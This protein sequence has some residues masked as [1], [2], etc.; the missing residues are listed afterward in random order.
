MVLDAARAGD[1]LA[2]AAVS[3][4]A[5]YLSIAIANL[6]CIV[7]PERIVLSGDLATYADMFTGPV[8]ERIQGLVP[9]MPE[10][11]ASE[12]GM[13]AAVWAPS[14]SPCARRATRCIYNRPVRKSKC[15]RR[16]RMQNI[17]AGHTNSYHTYTLDEALDGIATAGFKYVELSAVRGWTEHV[18]LEATPADIAA[19]KAKLA[20]WGLT[21]ASLSGHSD[22]TTAT[23]LVDGKKAVDLCPQ[24]GI[25]LMNTA[26]GG[27]YSE[28]ENKA[29]FMGN[30]HELAD[31]AA[32]RGVLI[33]LEVH[34]DIMATGQISIPLMEE[35][36][37]PNV[38]VNYD[39]A[40]CV[41]YGGVKACDDI[42]RLCPSSNILILRT[43]AAAG[44]AGISPRS[45]RATLTSGGY[46]RSSSKKGTR[47]RS[48]SR[49][50]SAGCPG[51]RWKRCTAR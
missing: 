48:A 36:S 41:F 35:I 5:D 25:T 49:S 45:A 24:L 39:T 23:G 7:D 42:G 47:R 51:R 44:A 13:D 26:I 11:V 37:R 27:H 8:R 50:S 21:A 19:I 16:T 3:E 22:L 14:P 34:G 46:S 38:G 4:V 18:P 9:T 2:S 31:Y 6:V 20:H 10:I 30:I 15:R 12:L 40:N 28:N 29:A 1:P 33:S 43:S 17:L 32:E